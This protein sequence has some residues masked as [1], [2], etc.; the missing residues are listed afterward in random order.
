MSDS[1]FV[2]KRSRRQPAQS[3]PTVA[4]SQDAP[5]A[6][7]TVS[8]GSA[9]ESAPGAPPN[10]RLMKAIVITLGVLIGLAFA[11][12]VVGFVMRLTGHSTQTGGAP[13]TAA[14][15]ELP[16]GA[17][18]LSLQ[19]AGNRLILGVHSDAGSEV[20]IFDSETGRLVGQIKPKPR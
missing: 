7:E 20:D 10:Y 6:G 19:V 5:R 16:A 13:Q 1:D 8:E 9:M 12:L 2:K 14:R 3:S 11:A 4:E 18:I 15:Y 17:K